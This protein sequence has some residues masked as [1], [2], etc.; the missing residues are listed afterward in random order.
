MQVLVDKFFALKDKFLDIG[1]NI[2][3]GIWEGIKA[4][5]TWLTNKVG[6]LA[7]GLLNAAKNVLGLHR[8][9]KNLHGL[10]ECQ[11]REWL[12]GLTM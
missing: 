8:H 9:Q 11:Q 4:G 7:Q 5:W 12:L 2:V 10:A 1:K 3:D 6:E